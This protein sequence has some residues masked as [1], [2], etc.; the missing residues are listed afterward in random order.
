MTE[1]RHFVPVAFAAHVAG[2]SHRTIRTWA[3]TG[4]IRGRSAD[5]AVQVHV[6]DAARVSAARARRR[7]LPGDAASA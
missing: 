5:G 1:D 7:R 3:R 6:G 4:T 2:R